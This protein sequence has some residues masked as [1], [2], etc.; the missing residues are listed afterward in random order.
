[1]SVAES[2]SLILQ[3]RTETFFITRAFVAEYFPRDIS[4]TEQVT[5]LKVQIAPISFCF[6]IMLLCSL[7]WTAMVTLLPLKLGR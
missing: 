3:R 4:L 2:Y 1:M 7:T 5:L 6:N